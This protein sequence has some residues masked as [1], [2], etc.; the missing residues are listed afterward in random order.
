MVA[1]RHLAQIAA[2]VEAVG[3]RYRALVLVAAYGGLRWA[4]WS[5]SRS[6]GSS[7]CMAG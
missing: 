3:A 1:V 5:A 6:S 4:S 7:C 2:L